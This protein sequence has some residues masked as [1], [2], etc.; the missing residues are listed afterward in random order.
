M[1]PTDLR[2]LAEAKFKHT[3]Y[4]KNLKERIEAELVVTHNG[5]L[6]KATPELMSFL[7]TW[8]DKEVFLEDTYGNPIKCNRSELLKEVKQKY[9]FAMN[10]W[11]IDF[12]KS[13]KI[14]KASDV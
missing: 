11:H 7:A 6:F 13:K 8:M 4:R 5:G 2:D 9:Q 14:R 3:L 10:A 1:E 12:E